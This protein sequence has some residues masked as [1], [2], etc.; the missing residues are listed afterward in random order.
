MR[1]A[2]RSGRLLRRLRNPTLRYLYFVTLTGRIGPNLNRN[3][4]GG[5]RDLLER[6]FARYEA[7]GQQRRRELGD[8]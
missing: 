8:G 4:V 1:P 3:T 2:N 7:D 6:R 5:L